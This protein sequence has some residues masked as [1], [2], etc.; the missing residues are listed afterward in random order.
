MQAMTDAD[1]IEAAGG[2]TAL[3]TRLCLPGKGA[4]QRVSNW[5]VRG[6]P[7][8]VLLEHREVFDE[9]KAPGAVRGGADGAP[10]VPVETEVRDVA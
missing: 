4:V 3:A 8:K 10:A 2:P 6:I 1:L 7:A 9:L 5:R